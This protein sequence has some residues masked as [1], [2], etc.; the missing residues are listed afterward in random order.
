MALDSAAE[1]VNMDNAPTRQEIA[2]TEETI[3]DPPPAPG[4]ATIS[5]Q[6]VDPDLLNMLVNGNTRD[7]AMLKNETCGTILRLVFDT[8]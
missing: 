3:S 6:E 4:T 7:M 2:I 1:D 5:G 8:F